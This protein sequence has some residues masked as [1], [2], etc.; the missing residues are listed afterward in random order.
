MHTHTHT[1]P[2][3]LLQSIQNTHT[4]HNQFYVVPCVPQHVD[5]WLTPFPLFLYFDFNKEYVLPRMCV[6]VYVSLCVCVT[7]CVCVCVCHCVCAGSIEKRSMQSSV[8]VTSVEV[9]PVPGKPSRGVRRVKAEEGDLP[10]SIKSDEFSEEQLSLGSLSEG[11]ANE[12]LWPS[13]AAQVAPET[14][15]GSHEKLG[16]TLADELLAS[17][18]NYL[19]NTGNTHAQ[20]YEL[21]AC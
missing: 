9:A 15:G 4:S 5:N 19:A 6:C 20:S 3:T 21:Y 11:E 14:L 13:S 1:T 7:V 12:S 2:M 18:P 10:E 8:E 17:D 16:A